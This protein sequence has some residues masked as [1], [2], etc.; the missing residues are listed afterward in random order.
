MGLIGSVPRDVPG[1]RSYRDEAQ[2]GSVSVFTGLGRA[3]RH[4]NGSD[5]VKGFTMCV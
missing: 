5:L 3:L 1:P 4:P 2:P